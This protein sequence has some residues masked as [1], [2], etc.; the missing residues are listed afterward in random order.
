MPHANVRLH[1]PTSGVD[2]L[3]PERN[4]DSKQGWDNSEGRCRDRIANKPEVGTI[5]E[6]SLMKLR[7]SRVSVK[8]RDSCKKAKRIKTEHSQTS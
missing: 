2:G 3:P 5:G 8:H 1:C 4:N 7:L 6:K